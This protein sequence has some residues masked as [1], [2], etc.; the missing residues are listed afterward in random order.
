ME[1]RLSLSVD[2][3]SQA[4]QR[5]EDYKKDLERKNKIF[6]ERMAAVGIDV[7]NVVMQEVNP[8]QENDFDYK[9]EL[10]EDNGKTICRATIQVTGRKLLFIEFGAGIRYST[11]QHPKASEFGYGVGTYPGQ[12]HAFD[13]KGWWYWNEKEGGFRKS[14]GIK[15]YMPVYKAA[16][17]MILQ[18]KEI[19]REVYA[20]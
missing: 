19:A 4:I 16:T 7:I 17:A 8:K 11:P 1:I 10:I 6:I 12:I 18:V 14:Y 3:I 5:L 15:A 2:E 13:P 20:S 9:A